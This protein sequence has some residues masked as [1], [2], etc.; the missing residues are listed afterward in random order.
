MDLIDLYNIFRTTKAKYIYFSQ[1]H[2]TFYRIDHVLGYKTSTSEFK[3]I[4]VISS[5]FLDRMV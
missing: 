3:K 5:I 4:E 2:G 1:V